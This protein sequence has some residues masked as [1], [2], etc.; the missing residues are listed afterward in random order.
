MTYDH[1]QVIIGCLVK[2]DPQWRE[3]A[4]AELVDNLRKNATIE[5]LDEKQMPDELLGDE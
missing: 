2:L 5:R 1:A 3:A 4:Q